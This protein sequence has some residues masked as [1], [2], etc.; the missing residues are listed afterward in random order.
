MIVYMA[1]TR[2]EEN[3]MFC[4]PETG[5]VSRCF[6]FKQDKNCFYCTQFRPPL[7]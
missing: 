4:D 3:R 6:S 1:L 7:V 5:D 2:R